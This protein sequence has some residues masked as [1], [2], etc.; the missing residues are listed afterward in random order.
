[1]LCRDAAGIYCEN[2]EKTESFCE[3]IVVPLSVKACGSCSKLCALKGTQYHDL[4]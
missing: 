2:C 4:V 3:Q 1:M